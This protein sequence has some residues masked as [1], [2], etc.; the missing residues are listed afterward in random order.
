MPG[1]NL[2]AIQAITA[3]EALPQV[4]QREGTIGLKLLHMA[5]LVQE[6]LPRDGLGATKPYGVPQ[7]DGGDGALPQE[8]PSNAR[9]K[10]ASSQAN[11]GELPVAR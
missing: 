10:S 9:R 8:P 1:R 5:K 3:P 11:Q 2:E 4:A 6:Q 7:R